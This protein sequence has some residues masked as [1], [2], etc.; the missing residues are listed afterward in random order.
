MKIKRVVDPKYNKLKDDVMMVTRMHAGNFTA[1]ELLAVMS[2]IVGQLMALQDGSN[3]NA[4][5]IA[6]QCV[7]NNIELGNAAAL[8]T[9]TNMETKGSA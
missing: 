6:V 2:Q 1:Q 5:E 8:E 3:P 9:A 4:R 7:M